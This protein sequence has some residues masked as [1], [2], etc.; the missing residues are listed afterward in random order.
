[1][2]SK[3]SRDP[4]PSQ[5][6]MPACDKGREDVLPEM[7]HSSSAR[8][9]RRKTR[10]VV[11]RGRTGVPSGVERENLSWG[12]AKRERVP[13]P[14]LCQH[15]SMRSLDVKDCQSTCQVGARRCGGSRGLGRGIGVLRGKGRLCGGGCH[16]V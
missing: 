8:T 3:Y 12:G 6:L 2:E 7:N 16:L 14:V 11:R 10:F 9:A 5:I 4:L 15:V 1:M 13:V